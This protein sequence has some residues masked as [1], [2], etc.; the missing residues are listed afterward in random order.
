MRCMGTPIYDPT[1]TRLYYILVWAKVGIA[2]K[3]S[4]A[5]FKKSNVLGVDP[6]SQQMWPP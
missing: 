3:V 2:T 4:I 6:N 5:E 1:Q